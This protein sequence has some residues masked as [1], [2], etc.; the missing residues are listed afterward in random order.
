MTGS[1]SEGAL[2]V[3]GPVEDEIA[4]SADEVVSVTRVCNGFRTG[5]YLVAFSTGQE[6]RLVVFSYLP[7]GALK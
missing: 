7:H 5:Q 4:C 2:G 3:D 1:G 6:L